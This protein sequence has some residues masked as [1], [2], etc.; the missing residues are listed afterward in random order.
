M[1]AN[2]KV[3]QYRCDLA[4]SHSNI[5]ILQA[6]MGRSTEALACYHKARAY[7]SS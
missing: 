4:A 3:K 2:P 5:G 1:R 6:E 7:R